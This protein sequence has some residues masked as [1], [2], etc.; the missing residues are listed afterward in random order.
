M[1][2]LRDI[3]IHPVLVRKIKK[4]YFDLFEEITT[5]KMRKYRHM[6]E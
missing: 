2:I 1:A 3:R 5:F 4:Y 6:W